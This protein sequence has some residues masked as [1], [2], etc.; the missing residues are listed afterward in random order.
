MCIAFCDNNWDSFNNAWVSVNVIIDV[1][2]LQSAA[3]TVAVIIAECSR[4]MSM[5]TPANRNAAVIIVSRRCDNEFV[6]I[7]LVLLGYCKYCIGPIGPSA[8]SQ[9]IFVFHIHST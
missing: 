8:T 7:A 3:I 1:I 4:M 9:F 5:I 2:R 6:I